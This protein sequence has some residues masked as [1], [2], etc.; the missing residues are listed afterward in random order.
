MEQEEEPEWAAVVDEVV[1]AAAADEEVIEA[2]EVGEVGD[3]RATSSRRL[4]C[5]EP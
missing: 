2:D 3:A 1:V 4:L 5:F